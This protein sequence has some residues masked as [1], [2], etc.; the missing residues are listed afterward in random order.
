MLTCSFVN[1]LY[2]LLI[3]ELNLSD[4]SQLK[5]LFYQYIPPYVTARFS[6][7]FQRCL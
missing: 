4:K 1:E 6:V 2:S 7:T 5:N 3:D